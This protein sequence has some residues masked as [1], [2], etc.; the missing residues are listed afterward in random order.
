MGDRI[1]DDADLRAFL[2]TLDPHGRD[3]LRRGLDP[4]PG[5]P[6]RDL[7]TLDALARSDRRP[8]GR[9]L[10]G[11]AVASMIVF[12]LAV[13]LA[14]LAL[15]ALSDIQIGRRDISNDATD[16]VVVLSFFGSALAVGSVITSDL[17]PPRQLLRIGA[18][19]AI[20]LLV[21]TPLV[22]FGSPVLS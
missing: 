3:T 4:R 12:S 22:Y 13:A 16:G 8:P 17:D 19:V 14:A 6:R 11:W 1:G 15:I 5:R 9:L 21:T 20:S 18:V 7:L 2:R 10:R